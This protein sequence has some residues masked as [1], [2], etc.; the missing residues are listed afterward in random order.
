MRT[1]AIL[2]DEQAD[3]S[4]YWLHSSYGGLCCVLAHMWHQKIKIYSKLLI[5]NTLW[6]DS[7]DNKLIIFFSY[8][9]LKK[10]GFEL[11]ANCL[12]DNLH[13]CQILF[14]RK[15]QKKIQNVVC[16]NFYP[17]CKVLNNDFLI[18]SYVIWFKRP[19]HKERNTSYREW[20]H[21]QVRQLCQN[22]FILLLKRGLL[23]Q[24]RTGSH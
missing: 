23:K 13:E 9:F 17:A 20:I 12:L 18:G 19:S 2:V 6:A 3:L 11:H 24:Q 22:C 7:A 16:W 8:F 1:L 10:I 21:F 14:S 5:L 4:L 15:S